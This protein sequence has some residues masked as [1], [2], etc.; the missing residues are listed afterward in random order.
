MQYLTDQTK[1]SYDDIMLE[2]M[3]ARE[4]NAK[5]KAKPV[6]NGLKVSEKGCVSM[7]GYGKFPI[8]IYADHLRDILGRKEELLQWMDDNKASLKVKPPKA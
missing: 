3:L 4:E 2:L 7:Y 5:L 8:S 6:K 1:P